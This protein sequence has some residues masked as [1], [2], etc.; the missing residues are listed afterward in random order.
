MILCEPIVFNCTLESCIIFDCSVTWAN[1]KVSLELFNYT[2]PSTVLFVTR[3]LIFQNVISY[4]LSART[5]HS[6]KGL[7]DSLSILSVLSKT[8][9]INQTLEALTSLSHKR[10]KSYHWFSELIGVPFAWIR[11]FEFNPAS[12]TCE[13]LVSLDLC[14]KHS[15]Y[16]HTCKI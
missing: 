2:S 15:H 5:S 6:D 13:T 8:V 4:L 11:G 10:C 1:D 12:A 16:H 9:Q 3:D 7:L 14:L